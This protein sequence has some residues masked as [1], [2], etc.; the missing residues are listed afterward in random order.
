MN[1]PRDVASFL[2]GAGL[3]V[4]LGTNMFFGPQREVSNVVPINAIFLMGRG[5][6]APIRSMTQVSEIRN[7][8]VNI[9]VRWNKFAAGDTKVRAIQDAL[10]GASISGYLDVEALQSEPSVI[11]EREE[12]HHFWLLS[13]GLAFEE[14]K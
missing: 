2:A 13:I 11:G 1:P 14:V 12:G 7:P 10:Q 6:P 5:G 8:I 3:G 4:T 9:R